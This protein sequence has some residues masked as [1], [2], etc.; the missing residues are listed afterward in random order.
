[1]LS[2][3]VFFLTK[4]RPFDLKWKQFSRKLIASTPCTLLKKGKNSLNRSAREILFGLLAP[5]DITPEAALAKLA[6]V[7]AKNEW[8]HDQKRKA[9]SPAQNIEF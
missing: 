5:S 3:L 2:S 1:V 7:L 8:S 4:K 9:N 6:Y